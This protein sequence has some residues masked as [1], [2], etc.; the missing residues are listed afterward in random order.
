M[1]PSD[2]VLGTLMRRSGSEEEGIRNMG[3]ECLGNL[4]FIRTGDT[5][6]WL[7]EMN[8]SDASNRA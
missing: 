5:V 1:G 2:R 8:R 4:V 6:K 3:A 7:N